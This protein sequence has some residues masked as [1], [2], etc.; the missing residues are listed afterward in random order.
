[1]LGARPRRHAVTGVDAL[2]GREREASELAARGRTN[3]Q[4]AEAMSV[5]PNTVEYHLTNAFRKLGI[6]NRQR[7][8]TEL[9][10][11][12]NEVRG[13]DLRASGGN[14]KGSRQDY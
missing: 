10:A 13:S 12:G 5:T 14:T 2:T 7:L 6:A 9:E 1:M 3:R 8:A 11:A 4:I